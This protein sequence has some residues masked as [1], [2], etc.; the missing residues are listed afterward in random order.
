MLDALMEQLVRSYES[1]RLSP[2]LYAASICVT[3]YGREPQFAPKLFEMINAMAKTSFSFLRSLDDLTRHPDV[4]EEMFYLMGRMI[5]HCP[6]PLVT[7]PL[8]PSLFQ[9]TAVGMRLEHRDANRGTLN[10]IENAISYGLALR[11]QNL[12]E[13]KQALEQALATEGQALAQNLALALMGELP[14]YNL[15][16]GNGS[17]AGI[18][19]KMNLMSPS[20]V[21]Q[22]MTA[23]LAPAPEH[24]R[25]DFLG[26]LDSGLPREDFNLAV[27]ALRSA[28]DRHRKFHNVLR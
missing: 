13:S 17:I 20:V 26:A 21:A 24:A 11:E 28:C 9:C 12:P 14:A 18:L 7:S 25:L 23:A 27:R 3:E 22:W 19:W 4:V 1:T 5:M 2:F 16:T 6:G 10:F 15:D 8:L